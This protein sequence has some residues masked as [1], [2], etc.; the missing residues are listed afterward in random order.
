MWLPHISEGGEE[1]WKWEKEQTNKKK[2]ALTSTTAIGDDQQKQNKEMTWRKSSLLFIIEP[3]KDFFFCLLY[4]SY[5]ESSN[6]V[7]LRCH[8]VKLKKQ[9]KLPKLKH[10]NKRQRLFKGGTALLLFCKSST[11]KPKSSIS[12]DRR[13]ITGWRSSTFRYLFLSFEDCVSHTV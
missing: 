12:H 4:L 7:P 10:F 6:T 2:P 5:E 1:M 13:L 11:N 3:C 8:W 9:K